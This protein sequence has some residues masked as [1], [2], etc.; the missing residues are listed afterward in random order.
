M[1]CEAEHIGLAAIA[2]PSK[3]FQRSLTRPMGAAESQ[4]TDSRPQGQPALESSSTWTL[5]SSDLRVSPRRRHCGPV[6]QAEGETCHLWSL[7][8]QNLLSLMGKQHLA[9]QSLTHNGLAAW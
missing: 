9:I 2:S 6:G 5:S 4:G 8:V 1:E 7:N 3:E